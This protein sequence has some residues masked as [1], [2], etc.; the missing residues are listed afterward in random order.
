VLSENIGNNAYKRA[1]TK[2]SE[3]EVPSV[4]F[5]EENSGSGA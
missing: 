2:I 4:D 1:I 5:I 3:I